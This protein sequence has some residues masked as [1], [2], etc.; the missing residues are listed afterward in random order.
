MIIA[1][2]LPFKHVEGERFCYFM[3]IVQPL[4]LIPS[5]MIVVKDSWNLYLNEYSKLK[6][7]LSK[8]CQSICLT[9]D[10]WTSVQNVYYM[11]LSVHIINDEWKL[12]KH[13][14]N[15]RQI[16]YHKSEII[17]NAIE[18]CLLGCGIDRVFTITID[19]ASSNDTTIP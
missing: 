18:K 15:F 19:N 12:H 13:I 3:S 8:K 10:C 6:S 9:K 7:I 5:R 16:A 2:E 11:C 14:L 1:D 17:G 4:F